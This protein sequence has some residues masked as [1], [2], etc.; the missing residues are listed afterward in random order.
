MTYWLWKNLVFVKHK[1]SVNW[2]LLTLPPETAQL[3]WD[4]PWQH[5]GQGR[6]SNQLTGE[7]WLLQSKPGAALCVS[8]MSP[9]LAGGNFT[10]STAWKAPDTKIQRFQVASNSSGPGISTLPRESH[11]QRSL[12]GYSPQGHKESDTTEAPEREREHLS[13]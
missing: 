4:N 1:E 12:Q 9:A 13:R 7:P 2:G 11:G 8:L 6:K 5:K 10:S 3:Y